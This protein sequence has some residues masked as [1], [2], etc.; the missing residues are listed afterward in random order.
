MSADD[1]M[2]VHESQGHLFARIRLTLFPS[3]RK[4]CLLLKQNLKDIQGETCPRQLR[5]VQEK[6]EMTRIGLVDWHNCF[7]NTDPVKSKIDDM[8]APFRAFLIEAIE[9]LQLMHANGPE[10]PE[11]VYEHYCELSNQVSTLL[12]SLRS[13]DALAMEDGNLPNLLMPPQMEFNETNHL[14]GRRD[15]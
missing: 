6:H 3:A 7:S 1:G 9:R 11:R 4:L 12:I 10:D 14:E 2:E 5:S 15:E 8:L 13:N